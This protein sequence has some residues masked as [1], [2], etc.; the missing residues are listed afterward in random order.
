MSPCGSDK[1]RLIICSMFWPD[2]WT[3]SPVLHPW[4]HTMKGSEMEFTENILMKIF[5]LNFDCL[6]DVSLWSLA[7]MPWG[8]I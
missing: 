3:R 7:W 6:S 8:S 2:F 4:S 1:A 5:I